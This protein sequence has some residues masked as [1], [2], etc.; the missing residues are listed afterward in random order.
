[1]LWL[2]T[3]YAVYL[4]WL[5]ICLHIEITHKCIVYISRLPT[6]AMFTYPQVESLHFIVTNALFYISWLPTN[7][8]FRCQGCPQVHCLH[9]KVTHKVSVY[10]WLH[11]STM[12]TYDFPQV[13]C[14]THQSYAKGMPYIWRLPIRC[15]L[16]VSATHMCSV[17]MPCAVWPY[18][19][20]PTSTMFTTHK[21]RD[22]ILFPT[23]A[24]FTYKGT[25]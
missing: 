11:T 19:W 5:R 18:Q 2:P 24:L 7:A 1:M 17:Y 3:T 23:T 21:Y 25:L 13:L 6:S 4:L 16:Y 12:F 22:Y 20:L 8:M 9:I 10:T 14:F 15:N